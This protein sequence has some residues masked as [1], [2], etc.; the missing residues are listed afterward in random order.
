MADDIESDVALYRQRG[1]SSC[2]SVFV[3]REACYIQFKSGDIDHSDEIGTTARVGEIA[4]AD[5]DAEG[6]ILGL[7]L[8]GSG[9]PCPH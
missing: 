1:A 5:F 8:V 2:T 9:K 3:P 4:I 7:E 6:R